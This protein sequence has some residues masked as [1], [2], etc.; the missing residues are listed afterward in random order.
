L[1]EFISPLDWGLNPVEPKK[2]KIIQ[3]L[4]GAPMEDLDLRC[5]QNIYEWLPKQISGEEGAFHG[6]YDARNRRFEP[7]QLVNLIAPWELMAG[8]DRYGDKS[9]LHKAVRAADWL[10]QC[11]LVITHPMSLGIGGV[12]EP[13][14]QEAWTKYSAEYVIL[15]LGLYKRTQQDSRFLDR[16]IQSGRFLIQATRHDYAARFHLQG[17]VS[18]SWYAGGWQAFGR[19]IEAFLNLYEVTGDKNWR[20]HAVAYGEYALGIQG[21]NGCFYLINGEYYNSD[22]AADPLRALVFLFEETGEERFLRAAQR[23]ADWHV[24]MQ[25][26]DG[27]WPINV[28]RDG[29]IVCSIVGPGDMPNIGIALLRIHKNTS[30]RRFLDAAVKSF[31][32]SLST[33]ITPE[34]NHPYRDDPRMRWGFW[35]WMPYYDYSV[36]ADQATH[37]IRGMFFLMDYAAS[38]DGE[39]NVK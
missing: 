14:S 4:C 23:F 5:R 1:Y 24:R 22:L 15:N 26:E 36:S 18:E 28:D 2:S 8:Y 34:S 31:Q 19:A 11:G 39:M 38:M 3:K 9:L 35:S 16:A 30:D 10:H 20:S 7:P 25:S 27:S 37:H 33:Q 17:T 13:G 12:L 21:E 29:N 6:F 32:Y